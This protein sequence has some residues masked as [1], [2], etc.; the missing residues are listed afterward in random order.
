MELM[1]VLCQFLDSNHFALIQGLLLVWKCGQLM[2]FIFEIS[3]DGLACWNTEYDRF[4]KA[5]VWS[6]SPAWEAVELTEESCI[7]LF[8]RGP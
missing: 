8:D 6:F 5:L 3:S 4:S 7:H 1:I 2:L